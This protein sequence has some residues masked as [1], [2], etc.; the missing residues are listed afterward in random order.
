VLDDEAVGTGTEWLLEL[1]ILTGILLPLSPLKADPD[2]LVTVEEGKVLTFPILFLLESVSLVEGEA[3]IFGVLRGCD[4]FK[5]LTALGDPFLAI[6][7]VPLLVFVVV[8][9]L[10]TKYHNQMMSIDI[11]MALTKRILESNILESWRFSTFSN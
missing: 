10:N 5:L 11:N 4:V 2:I 8:V 6:I 3:F 9:L 7:V 1:G